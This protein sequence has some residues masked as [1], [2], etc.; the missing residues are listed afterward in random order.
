MNNYRPIALLPNFSK[1]FEK[2][3]LNRIQSFFEKNNIIN[4]NQPGFQ[5]GKNTTQA[6][7]NFMQQIWTDIHKKT[8]SIGL[9]IGLSKAF[10]CVSHKILLRQRPGPLLFLVYVNEFPL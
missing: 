7:F 8:A 6:I 10:D 3:I 1:V 9:F 2:I 4:K 5:K